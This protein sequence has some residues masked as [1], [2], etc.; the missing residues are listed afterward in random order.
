MVERFPGVGVVEAGVEPAVSLAVVADHAVAGLAVEAEELV[1]DERTAQRGVLVE[2]LFGDDAG[3]DEHVVVLGALESVVVAERPFHLVANRLQVGRAGVRDQDDVAA[4]V[5]GLQHEFAALELRQ[6]EINLFGTL[7]YGIEF[8]EHPAQ[9]ALLDIF[10]H[11]VF[12]GQLR[13]ARRVGEVFQ[14]EHLLVEGLRMVQVGD[15]AQFLAIELGG[16]FQRR[17]VGIV[18]FLE[19][20]HTVL[21]ICNERIEPEGEFIRILGHG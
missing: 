18:V 20:L 7:P 21:Q 5:V 17:D 19:P 11:A 2:H 1:V 10:A 4:A 16:Q 3:L 6:R 14:P 15:A 13:P 9:A 8:V 12:V